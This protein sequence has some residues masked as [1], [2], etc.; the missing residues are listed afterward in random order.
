M[1]YDKYQKAR[2]SIQLR[3]SHDSEKSKVLCNLLE[4][5]YV[6]DNFK[7]HFQ[8]K[9]GSLIKHL[10]SEESASLIL[11]TAKISKTLDEVSDRLEEL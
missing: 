5:E 11:N 9:Y 3:Y 4:T 7:A 8:E 1:D 6:F 10:T 2:E